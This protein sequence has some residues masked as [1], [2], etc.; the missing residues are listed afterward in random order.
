MSANETYQGWRNYET[1]VVS[2]WIDNEQ[3]SQSYWQERAYHVMRRNERNHAITLLADELRSEHE[4]AM[5]EVKGV[6]SDML[7]AAME[8]VDWR[9]IASNMLDEEAESVEGEDDG[10]VDE[11]TEDELETAH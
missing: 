6:F 4:E 1:W 11:D 2:L 7:T 3:G 9:E 10:W 5:P 8:R